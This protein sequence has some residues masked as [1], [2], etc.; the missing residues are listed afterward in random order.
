MDKL[1]SATLTIAIP[2]YNRPEKLFEQVKSLLAQIVDDVQIVV[3]DNACTT[4][5]ELLFSQKDLEI[6][7]I[8]RNPFNIGA[9]ANIDRCFF[10]CQSPWLWVLSDDDTIS[11]NAIKDVLDVINNKPEALY[12]NFNHEGDKECCDIDSFIEVGRKSYSDLFWMSICVYNVARL[13][14]YFYD[15]FSSTSTM[16]PG[17]LMVLSAMQNEPSGVVAFDH[18]QIIC[19][20]GKEISWNRERFVYSSLF[21]INL[22]LMRIPRVPL[23]FL[24]SISEMCFEAVVMQYDSNRDII[25]ALRLTNAISKSLSFSLF[26]RY[27]CWQ[28]MKCYMRLAKHYLIR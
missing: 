21:V 10:L 28:A 5:V 18:H 3:L 22:I 9:D 7:K 25:R 16:Q 15:Y 12:L 1:S 8:Y 19:K 23:V 4:P 24:S 26:W 13:K 6:V 11:S 20:G 2:T 17:V 27:G 14:P